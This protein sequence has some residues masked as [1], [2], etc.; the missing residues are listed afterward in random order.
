MFTERNLSC[1]CFQASQKGTESNKLLQHTRFQSKNQPNYLFLNF[2]YATTYVVL[3]ISG[4][5]ALVSE[6]HFSTITIRNLT[7]YVIRSYVQYT[8]ESRIV[9]L[10]NGHLSDTFWVGLSNGQDWTYLSGYF[11]A[12]LD[13][14][15]HEKIFF[16]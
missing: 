6:D 16:V 7:T 5:T 3:L 13:R 14:F 10:S 12:S 15:I 1:L 9:R 11:L 4:L 2:W 8:S